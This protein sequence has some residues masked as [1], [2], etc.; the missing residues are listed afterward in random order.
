MRFERLLVGIQLSFILHL[1]A[2]FKSLDYIFAQD[3]SNSLSI[4]PE[5]RSGED[6]LP[7]FDFIRKFRLDDFEF[8]F[9]GVKKVKGSNRM[10]TAYRLSKRADLTLPTRSIFPLGLPE[11]FSFVATFRKKNGRKD[12]WFL[13]RINDI[14]GKPQFGITLNPRKQML[15]FYALDFEGKLQ[16]SR[17]GDVEVHKNLPPVH[18]FKFFFS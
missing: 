14:L 16:T 3:S 17:F 6:D 15:E 8:D 13:I 18:S 9:P 2:F 4:C 5:I 10:Q 1:V 7:G 11:E 12:P